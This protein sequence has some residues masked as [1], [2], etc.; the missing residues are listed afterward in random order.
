MAFGGV[1]V[2]GEAGF[3]ELE[4]ERPDGVGVVDVVRIAEDTAGVSEVVIRELSAD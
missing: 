3:G 1:A 4:S 2:I